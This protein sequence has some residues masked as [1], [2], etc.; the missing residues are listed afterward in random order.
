SR[1]DRS[2][3]DPHTAKPTQYGRWRY[4]HD[5][6]VGMN[7]FISKCGPHKSRRVRHRQNGAHYHDNQWRP[8]PHGTPKAWLPG[9]RSDCVCMATPRTPVDGGLHD[10]FF[11]NKPEKRRDTRH[12]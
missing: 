3:K 10:G 5:A 8:T 12:G 1:Y 9:D 7:L 4:W 6:V 2:R 11:G